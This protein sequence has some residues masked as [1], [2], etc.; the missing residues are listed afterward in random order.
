MF[1][2]I[3]VVTLS[4]LSLLLVSCATIFTGTTQKVELPLNLKAPK[5]S[6]MA[7]KWG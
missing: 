7:L 1:A 3:A 5:L 6:L 2:K 4:C